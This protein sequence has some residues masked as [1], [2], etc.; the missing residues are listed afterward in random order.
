MADKKKGTIILTPKKKGTIVLTPKKPI[1]APMKKKE[2]TIVLTPKK[3][4]KPL[5]YW[6]KQRAC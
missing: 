3:P 4:Q 6:E 2:G 1:I 5:K